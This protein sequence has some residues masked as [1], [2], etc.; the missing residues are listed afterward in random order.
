MTYCG[1]CSSPLQPQDAFCP[2]CGRRVSGPGPYAGPQP[3]AYPSSPSTPVAQLP[4]WAL[5]VL[6]GN[7]IGSATVAG[8]VVGTSLA[9]A[10]V[11]TLIGHQSGM[12]VRDTLT[13]MTA[14]MTGAFGADVGGSGGGV[15]AH[16]GAF[17]LTITLVTLAVAVVVFRRVTAGYQRAS[18]AVADAGRAA[19]ISGLAMMV[20]A[21]VFTT[22]SDGTKL[23]ASPVGAF[24]LTLLIVFLLLALVVL[25]RRDWLRT[26]VTQV[27]HD[28]VRAPVLGLAA[29]LVAL[30]FAG[31]IAAL[32]VLL[33]GSGTSGYT[34]SFSGG[35]WR[36]SVIGVIAFAGNLG[37]WAVTLGTGGKVGVFGL[38][39]YADL[40]N[41]LSSSLGG[42]SRDI[43][44]GGRLGWFTTTFHEPGLWVTLV[45]TPACLAFGAYAVVRASGYR[46][47]TDATGP[48]ALRGLALW[49]AS[50]LVAVP[51]FVRLANVHTRIDGPFGI[52][53]SPAVGASGVGATFLIFLYALV[54]AI[55]VALAVG[56][57][58]GAA[59]RASA[60]AIGRQLQQR[61]GSAP[62]SAPP[63]AGPPPGWPPGPPSWTAP[64]AGQPTEASAR[65]PYAPP[66]GPPGPTQGP[67]QGPAGP[68]PSG[69]R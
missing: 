51:Y 62:P 42:D 26:R 63:G 40:I 14:L 33:F 18:D 56:V 15:E 35:D 37:L 19:L 39:K 7:W 25:M 32:A 61:P 69:P 24:F 48:V 41:G 60:A 13:L 36:L 44:T 68:P 8:A 22:K 17:P 16:V 59:L 21:L 1:E 50:L 66:S 52:A 4:S 65:P 27:V 49:V 11:L 45:L 29:I 23:G 9:L 5:K 43:P 53:L 6:T 3:A 64:Q 47:R 31:I 28:W 38:D 30:P 2:S 12:G 10:L 55:V 20:F 58:D 46:S 54:V 34:S 67:P 57:L